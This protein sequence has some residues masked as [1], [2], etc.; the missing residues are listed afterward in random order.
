MDPRS[1]LTCSSLQV[2]IEIFPSVKCIILFSTDLH[3]SDDL[4]KTAMQKLRK[5]Q[6]LLRDSAFLMKLD[7][8]IVIELF[9]EFMP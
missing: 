3:D 1:S 7:K 4:K 5:N 6:E 8:N 9:K 2:N